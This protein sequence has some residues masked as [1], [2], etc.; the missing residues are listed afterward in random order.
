MS[1]RDRILNCRDYWIIYL[2]IV[3]QR[4]YTGFVATQQDRKG[5]EKQETLF[6]TAVI[7]R[8]SKKFKVKLFS[9]FLKI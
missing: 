1:P 4:C 6:L 8:K 2:F 7:G 5:K 3:S 9:L